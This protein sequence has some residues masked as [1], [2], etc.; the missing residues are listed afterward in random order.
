MH[1]KDGK[2][3]SASYPSNV[4]P[5]TP[6]PRAAIFTRPSMLEPV[7]APNV[8]HLS[9]HEEGE[10]PQFVEDR[11]TCLEEAPDTSLVSPKSEDPHKQ[12]VSDSHLLGQS[13]TS[14]PSKTVQS[15]PEPSQDESFARKPTN[16][17]WLVETCGGD[18]ELFLDGSIFPKSSTILCLYSF[19]F[20][21]TQ[22]TNL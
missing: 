13:L 18:N 8:P 2:E 9:K 1:P 14:K 3:L 5:T 16:G 19:S 12:R 7:P 6:D 17:K 21:A 20:S 15:E 10:S 4:Q 11:K 22:M